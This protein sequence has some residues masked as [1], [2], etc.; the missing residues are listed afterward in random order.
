LQGEKSGS[1]GADS[2]AASAQGA[3]AESG[4]LAGALG[5]GTT[6]PGKASRAGNLGRAVVIPGS[7]CERHRCSLPSL[8]G[9][10]SAIHEGLGNPGT[11]LHSLPSTDSSA[12]MPGG[13]HA[14]CPI[15]GIA[16]D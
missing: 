4:Y 5:P 6:P 16:L 1:D 7:T 8:A 10:R 13:A 14:E 2:R 15:P 11:R 12:A 3:A 9:L